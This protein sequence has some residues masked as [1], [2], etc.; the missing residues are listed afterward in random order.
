[1]KHVYLSNSMTLLAGDSFELPADG[2]YQI[3]AKGD[4]P[5]RTP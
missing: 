1:M 3:S 5:Q 4:F 2:W